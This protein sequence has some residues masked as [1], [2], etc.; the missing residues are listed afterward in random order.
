MKRKNKNEKKSN[1]KKIINIIE[2]I[3]ISIVILVNVIL[4]Y[5]SVK[6]PNKTPD[7]FGKKAF[8]IVS[9]SMIPEIDIGDIVIIKNTNS[10][11][12]GDTIAFRKNSSIIVHR[13]VDEIEVDGKI[14]YQTKGDNNVVPDTE[15]VD[16]E[17]IEGIYSY[18][19]PFIGN[20][21]LF[22]Y[23]NLAIL[24]IV[25]VIILIIK[26]YFSNNE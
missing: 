5:K 25:I 7:L 12:I 24:I 16:Y 21:L 6:N 13:I 14:M 17:N 11:K 19:I 3:V 1:F 4:V 10:V 8:V 22:L 26:Y 9:G 15:L 23:N 20:I 18:K 2:Y